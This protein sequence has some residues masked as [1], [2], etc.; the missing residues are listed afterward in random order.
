MYGLPKPL[1]RDPNVRKTRLTQG[2]ISL[3]LGAQA[4]E[5]RIRDVVTKGGFTRFRRVAE[6]PINL[7]FEA[8]P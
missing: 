1:L 5:A 7:I 4:G 8:R 6:A 2:K 3:A